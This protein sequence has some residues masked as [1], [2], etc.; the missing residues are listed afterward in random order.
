MSHSAAILRA[1][2]SLFFF[3]PTFRR[4]FSSSTTWPGATVTPSTQFETSGTSR[5]SSSASRAAQVAGHH[6]GRPGV[7]R[8]ADA[9]DRCADAGVFGDAASIVLGNVQVGTDENAL[10]LGLALGAQ[11]GKAEDVHGGGVD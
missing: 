5:P 2:S 3:S 9:G 4:Q 6:D 7:Q 11:I 1:R 8:H 10:A